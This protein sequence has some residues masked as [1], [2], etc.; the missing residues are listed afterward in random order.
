MKTGNLPHDGQPKPRAATVAAPCAV[1][2][3]EAV[4]KTGMVNGIYSNAVILDGHANAPLCAFDGNDD[5]RR[6]AVD[7]CVA[8]EV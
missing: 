2:A 4:E 7:D 6:L 8:D 3:V 1:N 5:I